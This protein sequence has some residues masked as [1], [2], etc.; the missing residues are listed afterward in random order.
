METGSSREPPANNKFNVGF[1]DRF[2]HTISANIRQKFP[3]IDNT[4]SLQISL[5]PEDVG[6]SAV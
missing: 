4:V 2:G 3:L 5:S 1:I 6:I